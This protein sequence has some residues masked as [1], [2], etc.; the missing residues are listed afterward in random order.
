MSL[1]ATAGI[2]G[3]DIDALACVLAYAELK[4][5][6][7]WLSDNFDA[8]IP[9]SIKNSE[10]NFHHTK[11]KNADLF[12][13]TD[14]SNPNFLSPQIP[15]EQ[16]IEIYDHHFGFESFWNNDTRHVQIESVGACATMI[17]ELFEKNAKK[18]S[19]E[20]ANLL[21][22]AILSNTLNF[23]AIMTS[24]RDRAAFAKLKQF[25]NLPQN[26]EKLYYQETSASIFLNPELAIEKDLHIYNDGTRI[27]QLELWEPKNILNELEP[28]E[29]GFIT[30]QAIGQ[31]KTYVRTDDIKLKAK[32]EQIGFAFNFDIGVSVRIMQRKEIIKL[33][34]IR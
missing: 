20:I 26:Y 17:Y 5:C 29:N 23:H 22:T 27:A 15:Q 13:I 32:L 7:A 9:D 1:C 33:L 14:V 34:G 18:P 28:I 19:P 3:T 24:E 10:L 11:P 6:D 25:I 8:T 16:I 21:Y 31:N 30:V 2:K 4:K 12:V